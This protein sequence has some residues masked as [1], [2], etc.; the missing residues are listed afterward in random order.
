MYSSTSI[1]SNYV[2]GNNSLSFKE[3]CLSFLSLLLVVG[4]LIASSFEITFL[5]YIIF[6]AC[7]ILLFNPVYILPVYLITSLGNNFLSFS[8]GIATSR[9]FGYILILACVIYQIR[10]NFSF[11][12]KH[13]AFVFTI[14]AFTFI[15]TAFF[16]I[17]DSYLTFIIFTQNLLVLVLLSQLRNVNIYNLTNLLVVSSIISILIIAFYFKDEI[18][19]GQVERLL[20]SE[21][22]SANRLGTMFSQLVIII[23]AGYFILKNK[24]FKIMITP[25]IIIGIVLTFFSGTRT[26]SLSLLITIIGFFLLNFRKKFFNFFFIAL[27]LTIAYVS[28]IDLIPLNDFRVLERFEFDSFSEGGSNNRIN[29]WIKLVPIVLSESPFIGYGFGGVN[30]QAFAVSN[31]LEYAAHNLLIDMFYQTGFL[32]IILFLSYF[33]FIAKKLILFS[34]NRFILLPILI[35]V[36]AI[37]NGLGE[38]IFIEKFFWNSIALALIYL[39]NT[40]QLKKINN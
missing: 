6:S 11:Q 38:T 34:H 13:L 35:L 15:S 19:A 21:D 23:F 33:L 3:K 40:P 9:I 31:G 32:G 37:I 30:G 4:S 36:T 27:F 14:F 2:E 22:S 26:A 17:T 29:N 5:H 10:N 7:F 8:N 1:K 16:S 28:F 18:I 24:T 39:N 20:F 12:K 25:I